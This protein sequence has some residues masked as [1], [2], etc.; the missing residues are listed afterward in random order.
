MPP[1]TGTRS[2]GGLAEADV[3]ALVDT[4]VAELVDSSPAALDTLNEL[5]AALGDDANFAATVTSLL[6]G[7]QAADAT[8][9]A[10]AGLATGADKLPYFTG[11][12]AASQADFTAF[13]RT[14]VAAADAAAARTALAIP[15]SAM[16]LLDEQVLGAP[17]AEIDFPSL[18]QAY[19]H[20][21]LECA[22]GG[23]T[24]SPVDLC[25]Q[26]NGDTGANYDSQRMRA[27]Y[28]TFSAAR[29][30]GLTS[31]R[32]GL[33]PPTLPGVGGPQVVEI[34]RYRGTTFRK[35][36]FSRA[37]YQAP[38]T[39]SGATV[40][41][42]AEDMSVT[43]G[44]TTATATAGYTGTGYKTITSSTS[45]TTPLRHNFTVADGLA[46]VAAPTVK[47]YRA[48]GSRTYSYRVN[49]GSWITFSPTTGGAGWITWTLPSWVTLG[50]GSHYIEFAGQQGVNNNYD[51]DNFIYVTAQTSADL[52]LE[53]R[54]CVWNALTAISRVRL[55]PASGNFIAGSM[56]SLYGLA[57]E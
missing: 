19:Q 53:N 24:A 39:A 18:S 33:V 31:A 14:L 36:L 9:S 23:S 42:E 26:F 28:A 55:F 34:P 8:L 25:L 35:G 17:A 52:V 30:D 15:S 48:A 10:L 44:W 4:A 46:I 47:V 45:Q 40:Q 54:A 22:L 37:L 16:V 43:T 41:V 38:G 29:D 51:Y 32:L 50:A 11:S 7:K 21:R 49:G 20:L 6:A 3:E 27:A 12:D 2:A 1:Y 57:A 56:A 5:A 13:A